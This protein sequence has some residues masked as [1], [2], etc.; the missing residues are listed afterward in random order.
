MPKI[1]A[2]VEALDRKIA[3]DLATA[4]A[5]RRR[6]RAEETYRA[7]M[8]DFRAEAMKAN[9]E[10]KQASALETEKGTM[11]LRYGDGCPIPALT[12]GPPL[13]HIGRSAHGAPPVRG[14][15]AR[16]HPFG[17]TDVILAFFRP[18]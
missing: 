10:A 1:E 5:A 2:K 15:G 6:R 14:K 11:S 7:C 17:P 18:A 3:E 13:V 16:S 4:E 8:A 12:P 9:Q